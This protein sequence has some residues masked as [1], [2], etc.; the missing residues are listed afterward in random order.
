[1]EKK[2]EKEKKRNLFHNVMFSQ[3][4][5]TVNNFSYNYDDFHPY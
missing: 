3:I 4:H 5:N 1:M 2:K